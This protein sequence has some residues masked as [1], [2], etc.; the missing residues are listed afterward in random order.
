[1]L[2]KATAR[3]ELRAALAEVSSHAADDG[4]HI[5]IDIDPVNML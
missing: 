2:V 5:S 4:V 3:N 1:V